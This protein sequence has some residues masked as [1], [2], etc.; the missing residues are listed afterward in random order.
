MLFQQSSSEFHRNLFRKLYLFLAVLVCASA[1]AFSQ[2]GGGI[3]TTGTNGKDIIQGRIIFPSG[4][5]VDVRLKVKLVT[6]NAGEMSVLADN[7][8]TFRFTSLGPGS[9]DV[10]LEGDKEY[11]TTRENVF[12]PEER[13]G[14]LRSLSSNTPRVYNV[15]IYLQPKVTTDA[16]A[17]SEVVDASLVNVPKPALDH[18]NKAREVARTGDTKTAVAELQ[19]AV[20]LSP[21]FTLAL[22]ELGVQYLKTGEVDKALEV[23]RSALKNAP[24]NTSVHLNYGI[25]L[26]EKKNFPE[27]ETELRKVVKK[28][29]SLATAHYYLGLDLISQQRLDEAATELLSAIKVG[30][31]QMAAAHYFLGGIYWHQKEYKRAADEL[32]TY[33]RLAPNAP[34]AEKIRGTIKEL[35]NRK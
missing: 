18:Y 19:A 22:N 21:D 26:L 25:A 35:R 17:K 28:S 12:I 31:D 3:D 27:A 23:L 1:P 6:M 30:G 14:V 11:Q 24:D 33:L 9:Y 4:Q 2:S 7:N 13:T 10:V 16:S 8:G 5:R 15:V 20:S 29:D 32:E 34:H